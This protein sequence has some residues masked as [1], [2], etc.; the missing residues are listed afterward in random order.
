MSREQS[1]SLHVRAN[2]R[3]TRRRRS[4]FYA[5]LTRFSITNE[6]SFLLSSAHSSASESVFYL[7]YIC[8]SMSSSISRISADRLGRVK[9]IFGAGIR[10]R[11]ISGGIC[12]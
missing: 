2:I 1:A 10:L 12:L 9:L 6:Q 4:Q 11:L 8:V 5:L 3:A 7:G